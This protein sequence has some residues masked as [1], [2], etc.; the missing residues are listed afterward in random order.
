MDPRLTKIEIKHILNFGAQGTLSGINFFNLL[1]GKNGVGKTG[2]LRL[3]KEMKSN[4]GENAV[5]PL[6]YK[7]ENE[8]VEN[9]QLVTRHLD[10]LHYRNRFTTNSQ[11]KAVLVIEQQD[12]SGINHTIKFQEGIHVLTLTGHGSVELFQNRIHFIQLPISDSDYFRAFRAL[13]W[14]DSTSHKVDESYGLDILNFG[15]QWIFGKGFHVIENGAV[16]RGGVGS[17]EWDYHD[18]LPSGVLQVIKLLTEII[19]NRGKQILHIDEPET[20]LEPRACRKLIQFIMWLTYWPIREEPHNLISKDFELWTNNQWPKKD[21]KQYLFDQFHTCH[22]FISSHSPVLI[23]EFLEKP[24]PCSVYE[25]RYESEEFT[26]TFTKQ[27]GTVENKLEKAHC[28]KI[29]KVSGNAHHILEQIGSHGS[30]ILQTNGV[31]WVEGPSDIIYIEKW[32]EMYATENQKPIFKKGKHYSFQMFGGSL[33][34]SI[35]LV[36][37]NPNEKKPYQKLVEMFSFSRNAF[38]VID[39]D[40]R[41]ENRQPVDK[42]TWSSAKKYIRQQFEKLILE[43]Y[44]IGMWYKEGDTDIRT[45]ENY[46]DDVSLNIKKSNRKKPEAEARVSSW[47]STKKLTDF[48]FNLESEI[49][50]LYDLI[51]RWNE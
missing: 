36:Q 5:Q 9:P 1:I 13:F 12:W 29:R 25:F 23:N 41:L 14:L 37:E 27:D 48:K 19:R 42:A 28:T 4:A 11:E 26:C 49:Q 10:W 38:V 17:N 18:T 40:C 8:N 32:L 16:M 47:D 2:F 39:S 50:I 33:L 6:R 51:R 20:N 34:D 22:I 45:I 15:L 44:A 46:L 24:K 3:L 21:Y 31:I 35:C 7:G 30:D 43:D